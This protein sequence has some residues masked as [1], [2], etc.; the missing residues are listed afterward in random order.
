MPKEPCWVCGRV[1]V[2]SARTDEGAWCD[3]CR[4]W[5]LAE[6]CSR[7]GITRQITVREEDGSPVCSVCY[8]R[9]HRG[10]RPRRKCVDC[11]EI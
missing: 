10:V 11:G 7:C 2:P 6:P 8:Q 4:K 5:A 9:E 3:T 1:V